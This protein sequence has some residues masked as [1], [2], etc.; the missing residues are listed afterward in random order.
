MGVVVAAHD[1]EL[2]RQVAVKILV[3]HGARGEILGAALRRE[4]QALARVTHPNVLSVYDAGVDGSPYLVMQL[5]DGET[6]GAHLQRT[7]PE[8]E[9]YKKRTSAYFPLPPKQ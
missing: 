2:D 6:L 1:P 3:E 4:A 9:A 5:V 8:Y 7:K